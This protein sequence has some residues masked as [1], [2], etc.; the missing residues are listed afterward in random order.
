MAPQ[1]E[2]CVFQTPPWEPLRS[3]RTYGSSD[4]STDISTGELLPVSRSSS[5]GEDGGIPKVVG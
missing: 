3:R 1:E 5:T 2:S 4:S